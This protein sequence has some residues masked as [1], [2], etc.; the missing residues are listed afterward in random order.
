MRRRGQTAGFTLIE[1][2]IVLVIVGLATSGIVLSVGAVTRARLRSSCW[3]VA[4]A[5]RAAYSHSVSTGKATRVVLDFE[6][7]TV[8]IEDT[9]GRLVL[10]RSDETGSGL[11]RE[12][13]KED[14]TDEAAPAATGDAPEA[15]AA[16]NASALSSGSSPMGSA[17]SLGMAMMNGGGTDMASMLTGENG[18]VTV[19]DPF[20]ASLSGQ[21]SAG[22]AKGYRRPSFAPVE[23]KAGQP[24]ELGGQTQF[25]AV[26]TPHD[27]RGRK[28]GKA[29]LYFFPGGLTEH[30]IVQLTDGE[31]RTYSLEIHPLTGRAV[32]HTEA[33]EPAEDLD[34]LQEGDE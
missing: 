13:V 28:E 16:G 22:S 8:H 6:A 3:T 15:G 10:N 31:E 12:D 1:V 17:L 26:Y 11:H 30:A 20:L 18:M 25:A 5:A 19:T 27:P 29:F 7:R 21:R 32:V 14:E 2:M 33:I 24:H 34:A 9:E 23:G 4:A